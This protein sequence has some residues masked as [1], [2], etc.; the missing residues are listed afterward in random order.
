MYRNTVQHSTNVNYFQIN[1][2]AQPQQSHDL[3]WQS[4]NLLTQLIQKRNGN[5]MEEELTFSVLSILP[6]FSNWR[7]MK[8]LLLLLIFFITAKFKGN[9]WPLIVGNKLAR[10]WQLTQIAKSY[11]QIIAY[12]EMM[13]SF[14]SIPHKVLNPAIL[15]HLFKEVLVGLMKLPQNYI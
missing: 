8:N 9:Y 7:R 3:L 5:E 6:G 10:K 13:K 12:I 11:L 14:N 1:K 15:L 4:R 2:F